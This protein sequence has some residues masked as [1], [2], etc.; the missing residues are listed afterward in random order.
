[1]IIIPLLDL[2]KSKQSG[3]TT[4]LSQSEKKPQSE[5][6]MN[7]DLKRVTSER[8]RITTASQS[9]DLQKKQKQPL[10]TN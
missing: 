6:R 1:M 9:L 2:N 10:K 8:R 7:Y 5:W 4:T 3:K